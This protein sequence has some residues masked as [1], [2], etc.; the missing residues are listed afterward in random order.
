MTRFAKGG[1][2]FRSC[3]VACLNYRFPTSSL[4]DGESLLHASKLECQDIDGEW[5]DFDHGWPRAV[6]PDCH[7]GIDNSSILLPQLEFCAPVNFACKKCVDISEIPGKV[8]I[9][10][11][12]IETILNDLAVNDVIAFEKSLWG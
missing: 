3:D 8:P 6:N 4:T 5:L 2:L 12:P 11:S 10:K 7:I 9:R 1:L